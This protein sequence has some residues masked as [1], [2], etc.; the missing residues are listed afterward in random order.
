MCVWW[1]GL[2]VWCIINYCTQMVYKLHYVYKYILNNVHFIHVQLWR[3]EFWGYTCSR[4]ITI[5]VY[6]FVK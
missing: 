4:T 5:R 1:F 3:V 2:E 6:N